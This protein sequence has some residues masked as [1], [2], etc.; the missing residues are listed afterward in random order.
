MA[1]TVLPMN[2]FICYSAGVEE[3]LPHTESTAVQTTQP[4][5]H[6]TKMTSLTFLDNV[7]LCSSVKID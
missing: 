7:S 1:F 5:F 3:N 6:T 2:L 4:H